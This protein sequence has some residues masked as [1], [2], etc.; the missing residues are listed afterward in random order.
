M[1]LRSRASALVPVDYAFAG[2]NAWASPD[3]QVVVVRAR[4]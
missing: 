2:V 1:V 4:G 3:C